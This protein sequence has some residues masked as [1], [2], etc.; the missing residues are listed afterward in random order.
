MNLLLLMAGGDDAFRE[1]GYVYPKNLTE[2][3]ELPLVQ[4]VI[5]SLRP[6]IKR[7]NSLICCIRKEENQ[8]VHTG[9]VIRLLA[10]EAHIVEI[11]GIT[12]GAACTA[13]LAVEYVNT[14]EPLLVI[15]GDCLLSLDLGRAIADFER[16]GLD[17]GI[18]V[19]D[20]V[21]PRW[22]YVKLGEADL[23]VE[24]AEKRPISNLATAGV[25]WFARGRDFV[26]AATEMIRKDDQV[27]G[28]FYVC[29]AYNQLILRQARIG[30]F[31]VPRQA[32]HSLANPRGVRQYEDFLRTEVT[33]ADSPTRLHDKRLVRR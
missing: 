14:D 33:H 2:I 30:I 10:P 32:Y 17:G 16:R 22:S 25:Y 24:T 18:V 4:R 31:R 5:E 29:P 19:F 6:L 11:D 8:Q 7:G 28:Q 9:S 21:H 23:V 27:N 26:Y 3:H 13:L 1:A 20:A 15:N 12:G